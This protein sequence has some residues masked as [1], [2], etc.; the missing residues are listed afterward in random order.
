MQKCEGTSTE[1][2]L[3]NQAIRDRLTNHSDVVALYTTCTLEDGSIVRIDKQLAFEHVRTCM[4]IL[5]K[6]CGCSLNPT[7]ANTNK[8]NEHEV[9]H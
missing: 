7:S 3:S 9:S 8:D 1:Q 4:N 5:K 6:T 2:A